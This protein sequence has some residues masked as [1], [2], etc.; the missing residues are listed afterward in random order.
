MLQVIKKKSHPLLFNNLKKHLDFIIERKETLDILDILSKKSVF[1]E[2]KQGTG[3]SC[4]LS[5]ISHE[6]KKSGGLVLTETGT[7]MVDGSWPYSINKNDVCMPLASL[8]ILKNFKEFNDFKSYPELKK[9][10]ENVK[11]DDATKILMDVLQILENT[12]KSLLII[13]Q[14]NA[15]YSTSKYFDQESKSILSYRLQVTNLFLNIIKSG[16]M[17]SVIACDYSN[18]GYQAYKFK[19]LIASKGGSSTSRGD[20][21]EKDLF[22]KELLPMDLHVFNLPNLSKNQVQEWIDE[23]SK[24]GYISKALRMF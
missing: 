15:L 23:F 9:M 8:Q 10:L 11:Q 20:L 2:G 17:K 16:K 22:P 18:T 4:L 1:I 6:W 19:S 21:V 24:Q 13:D 7:G 5:I 14:V 12:D 3:K